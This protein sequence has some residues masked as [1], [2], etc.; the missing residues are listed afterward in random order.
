MISTLTI[1]FRY[2]PLKVTPLAAYIRRI[3]AVMSETSYIEHNSTNLAYGASSPALSDRTRFPT[4]FRTHP[5]ATI[6]NPT[7]IKLFKK[8]GWKKIA[9][10]QSVE[11]VFSSLSFLIL[12]IS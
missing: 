10:L 11:E 9:I 2:K 7:R 1:F 4:L 5:S 3:G 6:H 12:N 8:F